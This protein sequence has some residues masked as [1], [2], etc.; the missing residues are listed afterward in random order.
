MLITSCSS[1]LEGHA[2]QHKG[3]FVSLYWVP[4]SWRHSCHSQLVASTPLAGESIML[5]GK[6]WRS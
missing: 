3:V 1:Q 2:I 5:L 6:N 4:G